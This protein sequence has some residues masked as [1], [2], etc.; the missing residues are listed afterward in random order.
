MTSQKQLNKSR[1]IW[2][3]NNM[4]TV[5]FFDCVELK[6]TKRTVPFAS[7]PITPMETTRAWKIG[8]PMS[9][10]YALGSDIVE[11][12]ARDAI[13]SMVWLTSVCCVGNI[14]TR[15]IACN[16]KQM[17]AKTSTGVHLL[18]LIPL[19]LV[20]FTVSEVPAYQMPG[21]VMCPIY[22]Q[23]IDHLPPLPSSFVSP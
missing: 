14:S 4:L 7:V 12:I 13:V 21:R 5:C 11:L 15:S 3:M 22:H 20:Y 16:I 19:L 9:V 6:R 23:K 17:V 2:L 10:E 8:S 1:D 18:L